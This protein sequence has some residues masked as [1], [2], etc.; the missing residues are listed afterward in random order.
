MTQDAQDQADELEVLKS[1]YGDDA[2]TDSA[3]AA[4]HQIDIRTFQFKF[5]DD[6]VCACER[7]W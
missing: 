4:F 2:S 1:I 5:G 7:G 6:G 3:T